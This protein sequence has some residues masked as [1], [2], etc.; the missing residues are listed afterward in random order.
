MTHRLLRA[1]AV[2]LGRTLKDAAL[3]ITRRM[4]TLWMG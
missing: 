3:A 2:D 1:A 4:R